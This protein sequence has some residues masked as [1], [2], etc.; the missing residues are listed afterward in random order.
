[1][2]WVRRIPIIRLLLAGVVGWVIIARRGERAEADRPVPVLWREVPQLSLDNLSLTDAIQRIE[3]A[4][5]V[6]IDVQG[7]LRGVRA[8]PAGEMAGRLDL[9]LNR[10]LRLPSICYWAEGDHVIVSTKPPRDR[11]AVFRCYEVGDLLSA[12][13][14][15]PEAAVSTDGV[16]GKS[17][18]AR[19]PLRTMN[20]RFGWQDQGE[21]CDALLPRASEFG[22][23]WQSYRSAGKHEALKELIITESRYLFCTTRYRWDRV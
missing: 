4:S 9:V 7:D 21:N 12:M 19:R 6:R 13:E 23:R 14:R 11:V 3:D 5:G 15:A 22:A 10:M 20:W 16:E 17:K 18:V 1:M 2:F 8:K